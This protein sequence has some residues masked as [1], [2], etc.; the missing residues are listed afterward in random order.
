MGTYQ[1][2]PHDNGTVSGT[3]GSWNERIGGHY[4]DRPE[5]YLDNLQKAWILALP[6]FTNPD[7]IDYFTQFIKRRHALAVIKVSAEA[8][9]VD[10]H[11]TAAAYFDPYDPFDMADVMGSMF[12]NLD[13]YDVLTKKGPQRA[14]EFSWKRTAEQTLEVYREVLDQTP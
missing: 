14:S 8:L 4:L 3:S 10:P 1:V 13:R 5:Y 12:H 6:S 7:R 11:A 9:S 2:Y